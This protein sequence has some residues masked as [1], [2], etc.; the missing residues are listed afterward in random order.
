MF[1][2]FRLFFNILT[3]INRLSTEVLFIRV[4]NYFG[5]SFQSK[6]YYKFGFFEGIL[7]DF[8]ALYCSSLRDQV[9]WREKPFLSY[10]LIIS[11]SYQL[12]ISSFR[13][14]VTPFES[15]KQ[16]LIRLWGLS[17]TFLWFILNSLC[18][19]CIDIIDKTPF[20]IFLLLSASKPKCNFG[21][22]SKMN[23]T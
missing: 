2:M 8:I 19:A 4:I 12:F 18:L 20:K 14:F 23:I 9:A 15:L 1:R 21:H 16:S 10:D 6:E 11:L 5:G 3:I 13:S 7:R 22:W 17:V